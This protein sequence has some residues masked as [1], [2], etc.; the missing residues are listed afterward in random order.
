[1]LPA[2][3]RIEQT[4]HTIHRLKGCDPKP[5]E[6]LVHVAASQR[7]MIEAVR[8]T[9]PDVRVFLSEVNG[10]PGGARN[11]MLQ[12]ARNELVASFDDDSYPDDPA[13]F[14]QLA[15]WF[16]RLPEAS[17]LALN[18]YEPTQPVPEKSGPPLWVPDFVGCGCA[19]RRSHFMESDGYVPI[20]IAYSMEE[21]D[22][23]L[24]YAARGRKV[25]FVPALLIYHDTQLTHHAS[26]EVA[27]M[28]VAN[29]AL[30]AYLRYPPARWPLALLQVANKWVDTLKRR[31]WAGALYAFPKVLSQILTYHR[32]RKT[33]SAETLDRQRRLRARRGEPVDPG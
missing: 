2:H 6:I 33:V 18:I 30:F 20:P 3:R 7:E 23:A 31:R 16:D 24:R 11:R 26:A 8:E 10:G 29:T 22:L 14:G 9:H 19:Y 21:A 12:E 15:D 25:C 28:Q 17:I 13:F 27:A 1:M 4:L 32:Y 5:A